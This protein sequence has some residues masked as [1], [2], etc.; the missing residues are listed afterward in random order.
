L[1]DVQM[2]E[3]DGLETAARVRRGE[4]GTGRRVPIIAMTAMAMKGDRERC[5]AAGM[6]HYVSKPLNAAELYDAL[7]DCGLRIADCG[8]EDKDTGDAGPTGPGP[9][10]AFSNRNPQSAIRNRE[11]QLNREEV[12]ARVA[13]DV[14]LLRTLVGLFVETCPQQMEALRQAIARG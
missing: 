3:L 11:V 8:S 9:G 13:G 6:D 4:E 7:A 2:P 14:E 5:L 12:L 1:M 10:D